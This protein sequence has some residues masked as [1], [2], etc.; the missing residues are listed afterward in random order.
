MISENRDGLSLNPF[1]DP[2]AGGADRAAD[3]LREPRRRLRRAHVRALRRPEGRMSA[4][5]SRGACRARASASSWPTAT[6][7]VEDVSL[8]VRAGRD[9]RPRRRVRERARRRP[10]SRCSATRGPGRRIVARNGR[11]RRPRALSG[12][13]ERAAR[14]LRGRVVSYV[15]QDPGNALNPALRIGDAIEDMLGAHA[16]GRAAGLCRRALSPASTCPPTTSSL[17]RYPHQLSGGQQQRVLDRDRARLRAAARRAGRADD[18]P[19]RRHPGAR[20]RRDRPAA[21]RA[22]PRDGV[23][24]ARPRRRRADRRPDRGH[25]RRADRRGGPGRRRFSRR[26]VTRTREASSPRSRPPRAAP[27][28]QA[29]PASPSGVGERPAGC[30]FA[31]RCPQRVERCDSELPEL[32]EIGAGRRVRCFEW[33]RTPPLELPVRALERP[34]GASAAPL[35][36]VEGLRAVSRPSAR[37]GRRGRGRVLR[38][39]RRRVR[40]AR[41]RVRQRQDDDRALRRRTARAGGRPDLA[42]RR[43]AGRRRRGRARRRRGAASRSSSRTRTTR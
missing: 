15:P 16:T 30:A 27:A 20:A 43:V 9:P 37:A 7:I 19:R 31:P 17:R 12:L 18:R 32:E 1:V 14:A 39:G 11:G 6:P 13:G 8:A 35:L 23:R 24:L 26:R 29:C 38:A 3:D 4:E 28:R 42:R 10:R 41:G 22:G 25:V 40:R 36:A 5:P 34:V 21:A 2:R 33:Q